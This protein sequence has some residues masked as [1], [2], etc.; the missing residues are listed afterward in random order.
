MEISMKLISQ[1]DSF[2]NVQ[3][4]VKQ[5]LR[6]LGIKVPKGKK[7]KRQGCLK[8]QGDGHGD[9]FGNYLSLVPCVY[10]ADCGYVPKFLV[11]AASLIHENIEQEG[12]F[13]KSGAVSRQKQLKQQIENGK[14]I[15][16]ANVYDVTGLIKQFFRKLPDPLLTSA[17]HDSFIKC[18]HIDQSDVSTQAV[19]SLCLLLPGEHLSTLRYV[20]LLLSDVANCAEQNKMDAPN[21][22]VVLAPNIMHLNN[23]TEKMNSSE[24]KLLQVQT[25]IVEVLIRSASMIGMVSPEVYEKASLITEIFGTDDELDASCDTLEESRDLKKKEKRRKRSGS[26]QGVIST[27]AK[28]VTKWRRSTDGKS[29]TSQSSNMSTM[30]QYSN[31]SHISNKANSSNLQPMQTDFA[32]ATPVV[33]RKRKASGEMPFSASKKKAILKNLPNQATL[34]NTPYTPASTIKKLDINEMKRAGTLNTPSIAFSNKNK[35]AFSATPCQNNKTAR[36]KLGLFSPA[37]TRKGRKLSSS[38]ISVP[39]A[40]KKN[41]SKGIFRRF[42]GGKGD[43]QPMAISADAQ[44]SESIGQRLV[45][46]DDG[47]NSPDQDCV[48]TSSTALDVS[49]GSPDVDQSNFTFGP[50]QSIISVCDDRNSLNEGFICSEDVDMPQADNTTLSSVCSDGA[51]NRTRSSTCGEPVR[52]CLSDSSVN[53]SKLGSDSSVDRSDVF[54]KSLNVSKRTKI[55]RRGRPNSLKAGLLS[56][57]PRKVQNLRRSFGLDKSE[58][59]DPI[60]LY[61][62]SVAD[63]EI[64]SLNKSNERQ[65]E[66]SSV[67]ETLRDIQALESNMNS[68]SFRKSLSINDLSTKAEKEIQSL[69]GKTQDGEKAT[70]TPKFQTCDST[71]SLLSGQQ[72]VSASPETRKKA[73]QRSL[74]TDSGKGSMFDESGVMDANTSQEVD[75]FLDGNLGMDLIENILSAGAPSSVIENKGEKEIRKSLS[76]TNLVKGDKPRLSISRSQSVYNAAAKRQ[77]NIT[78]NLQ[79]STETHNLLSRAG[80]ISKKGM[81]KTSDDDFQ[82]MGPPPPRIKQAEFHKPK[83]ESILELKVKHAGRVA[84][85]IKQFETGDI[86]P[87]V[88]NMASADLVERHNS[89]LRFP[90][91]VSRKAGASPLKLPSMLTRKESLANKKSDC[92]PNKLLSK[93][94]ARLPISTQL[95]KPTEQVAVTNVDTPNTGSKFRKPVRRPSIYYAKDSD[96]PKGD[97]YKSK[98]TRID[99]SVFEAAVATP[100][101]EEPMETSEDSITENPQN[102]E[103]VSTIE[104]IKEEES[105]DST[106]DTLTGTPLKP[107]IIDNVKTSKLPKIL[108]PLGD[109]VILRSPAGLTPKQ[110]LQR[111]QTTCSPRSP[112]KAVKR[113]GSS[114]GSPAHHLSRRHSMS[115]R[116]TQHKISLPASVPEY[117]HDEMNGM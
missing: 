105:N 9:I 51:I 37:S 54:E 27:I 3:A 70:E 102:K 26:F 93:G 32:T 49:V 108:Q 98:D 11:D 86:T 18:Y 33:I 6:E 56:G 96:T 59:S 15:H 114:P 84:A 36:K 112:I 48:N 23:K 57:E 25:A 82:V 74:S 14:G 8:N 106:S 83:R 109:S 24:E 64:T 31:K 72:S 115:P 28:S 10:I 107:E 78:P 81:K 92:H 91:C 73:M 79:I 1:I 75:Q 104:S 5:D 42:S 30:S 68:P 22:A 111:S 66:V 103:N 90:N 19:L 52:S 89:P 44:L 58:I 46:Q 63:I 45:D 7:L 50:D 69:V 41:K 95:L 21:L 99:D 100:L 43:N 94:Q 88:E 16:G 113:L 34:A 71:D 60:P 38:S 116:R 40:S 85:S 67:K 39:N 97:L 35:L 4:L 65:H 53:C 117:L 29:N 55:L 2:E 87:V 61:V 76:S 77:P 62:P 47:A 12:L 13:R 17:Y 110:M 101:P 20:M 80:Y